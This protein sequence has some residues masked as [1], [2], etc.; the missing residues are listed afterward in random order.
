[1]ISTSA[2]F[3]PRGTAEVGGAVIVILQVIWVIGASMIVL[4]GLQWFGRRVCLAVGIAILVGHNLLDPVWPASGLFDQQWPLWV[5][6]H[7][8]MAHRAGPFLLLFPIRCCPGSASCCSASGW[9]DSLNCRRRGATPSCSVTGLTLVVGFVV[10]R[11]LAVYGDPNPWQ[12]QPGGLVATAIDFLNTTK[13][14]PSL[15]FMMMTLGP[16]AI[17]CA[18]ADRF[19]GAMK[20]LLVMFGRVPFAFYVTHFFVIHALS[21]CLGVLQGFEARQ[22][23]TAFLF[24]PKGS[25]VG[26]HGS[27]GL[28]AGCR[29][30]VSLLPL[31]RRGQIA[32][33]R[34]VVEL[35]LIADGA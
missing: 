10:L 34:L 16:A 7:A 18:Y 13:Y 25:G 27:T 17:V 32:T 9:R 29:P 5:A 33:S 26:L 15:V 30:V 28:A 23:M 3:S 12:R 2:T 22:F 4:S 20:D 24:F 6:L 11:A 35:S 21:V 14:P 1:M 31:G 8:Q 19:S